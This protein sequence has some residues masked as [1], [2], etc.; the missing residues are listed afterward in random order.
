MK[1]FIT[2]EGMDGSGKSTQI[3]LLGKSL[4]KINE[5]YFLTREPGGT[6]VSEEIRKI[7]VRKTN[8][9]IKPK[10]ELLLI[11]AARH[12][13]L[14]EKIIPNLRKRMV[15]CDRFY[16]STFCYQIFP[17][18]LP[19]TIL[20]NLHKN[21]ADNLFPDITF[22]IDTNPKVALERSLKTK[23]NEK[24]FELKDPNYHKYVYKGFHKLS[25]NNKNFIKVDGNENIVKIHE[26]IIDILNKKKI[27]KSAIPYYS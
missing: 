21:F 18:S 26:K 24:R 1:K 3:D 17:N 7:L 15:L 5:D 4:K 22:F 23:N 6:F 12:Q 27:T 14:V 20:K 11:Y 8:E 9:D 25:K 2:F 13:H 16:H 19:L 10:T